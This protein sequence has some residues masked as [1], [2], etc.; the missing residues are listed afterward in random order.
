MR[1]GTEN[2][3][4]PIFTCHPERSGA[5]SKSELCEDRIVLCTI[6]DL[7]KA[8]WQTLFVDPQNAMRFDFTKSAICRR[9]CKVRLLKH[10][11]GMFYTLRM[12]RGG[13]CLAVLFC[14]SSS[15]ILFG[16]H[17]LPRRR[18]FVYVISFEKMK[19]VGSCNNNV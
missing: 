11:T 17:L 12:T 18:L 4:K 2:G 15:V 6:R 1:Y 8:E 5:K 16:S 10:P 19:S 14:I 9:F 3:V 7:L 13:R